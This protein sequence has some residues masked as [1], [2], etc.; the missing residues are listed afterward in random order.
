MNGSPVSAETNEI[1]RSFHI[2][3]LRPGEHTISVSSPGFSSWSKTVTIHSGRATEFWNVL[4]TRNDYPRVNLS[5]PKGAFDFFPSPDRRKFLIPVENDG[6]FTLLLLTQATQEMRQIFSSREFS[7]APPAAHPPVQWLARDDSSLLLSLL[8]RTDGSPNFFL[9]N[10]DTLST[11][12][13]KDIFSIP[14]LRSVRPNP[15]RAETLV[16]LS[17]RTLFELSVTEPSSATLLSENVD[18]Y[19]FLGDAVIAFE[20]ASG[21][22]SKIPRGNPTDRIQITTAPPENY[23][24]NSQGTWSIIAYDERRIVVLN[25]EKGRLFF[26]NRGENSRSWKRLSNDATGA[27]FSDDGKKL[28]FWNDWEISTVFTRTWEVQPV[29]E[30][31]TRLDIGRFSEK[32]TFVQ[33]SKDYEHVIFSLGNDIRITELDDRGGRNTSP[34]L[35]L[36]HPP[37]RVSSFGENNRLIFLTPSENETSSFPIFSSIVFPEP[38]GLFG[39][40]T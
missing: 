35:S 12:N 11:V 19:D 5:L 4:L 26:L 33:W 2:G 22:L 32:I 10:S 16:A 39:F 8:S 18:A 30:E 17:G 14:H 36:P 37:L 1:N 7:L 40:G 6:E 9:V 34:I 13:V 15:E 31:G 27:Q 38:A 21:I 3:G 23:D 25:Q 29:R 24:S 28:L 20:S